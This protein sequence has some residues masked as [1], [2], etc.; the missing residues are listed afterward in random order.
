MSQSKQGN[1]NRIDPLFN[2]AFI[3]IFGRESSRETT[4]G[5]L[6]S[7]FKHVGI[8]LLEEIDEISAE[9]TSVEGSV[10]CKSPRFDVRLLSANRAIG[11]EAQCYP[12][13][14]ESRSLFYASQL[15]VANTRRGLKSFKDIPQV[16]VVTLLSDEAL[17]PYSE[18]FVAVGGMR[19][20]PEGRLRDPMS[21][22]ML[23]VV[24]ELDK[25]R[26]RYTELTEEV[27]EDELL[28]WAYLLVRG[29]RSKKDVSEIMSSHH[30]IEQFAELYGYAVGDP[31]VVKAYDAYQSAEL[32]YQS[33]QD[34][35]A[36]KEREAIERGIQ[37]GIEQGIQQG[38][39]QGIEQGIERG[40]GQ[41]KV[42][43]ARRL[44]EMG[45]LNCEQVSDATGLSIT[46]VESIA[47][48]VGDE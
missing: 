13:D 10:N 12:E 32:E 31:E 35:L 43:V 45:A 14:V 3:R 6:N 27:L 2:E 7:I 28:S 25:V 5:L 46:E 16:I 40:V 38:I 41:E 21:S 17:F 29:Y 44:L 24:V 22:R 4:K 33:R 34:Y 11:L 18:D 19:W 23:F 37:Q 47:D 30:S 8:D 20:T 26:K 42:A 48:A 39:Q 9:H 15:M 1:E 36:R